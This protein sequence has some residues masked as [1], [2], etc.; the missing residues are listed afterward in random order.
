MK[1]VSVTCTGTAAILM[2][3][4]TEEMLM[5]IRNKTTPQ[6]RPGTE[7]PVE[8]EAAEKLMY[9]DAYGHPGRIVL[10][11]ENLYAALKAAGRKVRNGKYQVSTASTTTLFSFLK[12][13]DK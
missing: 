7:W 4:V 5:H 6:K 11:I 2:N 10:P 13:E 3:P 8:D 12:I 9:G 1:R